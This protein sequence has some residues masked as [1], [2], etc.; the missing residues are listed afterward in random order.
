MYA[1]GDSFDFN[2]DNEEEDFTVIGNINYDDQDYIIAQNEDEDL[3]V[4]SY[5]KEEDELLLVDDEDDIQDI[6]EYWQ[7]EYGKDPSMATYV[8]ED[9]YDSQDTMSLEKIY[10]N[11]NL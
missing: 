11:K 9:Y 4:F 2:L 8:N 10:K 1:E 5:D 6:I 7:E 3:F